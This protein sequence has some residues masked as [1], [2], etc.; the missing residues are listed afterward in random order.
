[1][2]KLIT[3]TLLIAFVSAYPQP[4]Q[5]SGADAA[6]QLTQYAFS[7]D[8][9]G[10]FNYNFETSNGIKQNAEGN[11]KDITETDANGQSQPGKGS[12]QTGSFSYNAPDGT[13]VKV[14][15]VADENGF[16]PTGEKTI[17]KFK[18]NCQHKFLPGSHLPPAAGIQGSAL[19]APAAGK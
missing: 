13:P 4:P 10:H 3:A 2:F 6:A 12:V 14:D 8:G 19:A 18:L 5:Q 7:D 1:M 16:Q 9:L 11:L 15:W 17:K